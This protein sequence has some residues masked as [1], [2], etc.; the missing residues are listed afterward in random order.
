MELSQDTSVN[1]S[2]VYIAV[3]MRQ[4]KI[5]QILVVFLIIFSENICRTVAMACRYG[6]SL[7]V[8]LSVEVED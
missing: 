8:E 1:G 7:A 2:T 3:W 4:G 6:A 5:S